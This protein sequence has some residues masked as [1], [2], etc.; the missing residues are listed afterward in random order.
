MIQVGQTLWYVDDVRQYNKFKGRHVQ[1]IKIGR[2]WA[3]LDH[4]PRIDKTTLVADGGRCWLSEADYN[5]HVSL[6]RL[7]TGFCRKVDRT[8]R[9]P[10]GVTEHAIRQ[11]AALLNIPLNTTEV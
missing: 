7:W 2:K 8:Y 5:A 1:V 11:A 9:V 6:E 10:D 3:E 4:A